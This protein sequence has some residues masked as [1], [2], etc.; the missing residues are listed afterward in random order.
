[1]RKF[2]KMRRFIVVSLAIILQIGVAVLGMFWLRDYREWI[3]SALILLSWA[4]VIF[5]VLDRSNPS[6]KIAWVVLILAFPVAGLTIY[7]LFGG[8]RLSARTRLKMRRTE[9][10]VMAHLTQNP[11][12]SQ[13][14]SSMPEQAGNHTAYIRNATRFPVYHNSHAEYFPDG[15]LC[16]TRMLEELRKAEH[17]I[18][19]EYFIL[20]SGLMWDEILKILIEK[21]Q[22]GLD[23]RV[24]YDDFGSITRLPG[25]YAEKLRERG[26]ACYAVNR[27][28][29]VLS[30]RLNNRDHRKLMII[31]GVVSF[32]GGINL[33]DEYINRTSPLGVWKDC[34][35]LLRGEASWAMAAMFLTMWDYVTR[36]EEDPEAFRPA[37]FPVPPEA[38]GWI[39]PFSDS[40]LDYEDVGA[41]VYLDLIGSARKRVW[42]MTPYL[43]LD[44]KM[45]GALCTAAKSGVD[46]RIV[47]PHIP[48]KP[49]VHA[50]TRAN[51]E[52]LTEAGVRI[53]EYKP[54][55]VHAKVCLSDDLYALVGTMNM[56]YRSLYLHFENGVYLFRCEAIEQIEADFCDL[57]PAC[58][59]ITYAQCRHIHLYQRLMRSLLRL[60]APLM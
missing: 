9:D 6:F 33:A 28:V 27:Y 35:I 48:D 45:T 47:T 18:F 43:I 51:Y 50:V 3:N 15:E 31:D 14:L 16:F 7:L 34:G 46:V 36:Q 60:F 58:R 59:E 12:A 24:L 52:I 32:T 13:L 23:V 55:F 25:D 21:A 42:I 19:L 10:Q 5:I 4:A 30:P 2:P 53:F 26:I 41:T 49:Y 17:Y 56:D 39:Q 20:E 11:D 29:P 57:F 44:D 22:A 37:E 38:P 54:G 1:M 8:N 40:P